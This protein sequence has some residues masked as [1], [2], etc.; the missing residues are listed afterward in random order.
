VIHDKYRQHVRVIGAPQNLTGP[1]EAEERYRL[2]VELSPDAV[3][4]HQDLKCVYVNRACVALLGATHPEELLG[5]SVLDIVGPDFGEVVRERIRLLVEEGKMPPLMEQT[6]LRPDGSAVEVEVSVGTCVFRG[7]PAIQV[8]ARDIAERKRTERSMAELQARY[9]QLVE[10]SPDA[11]HIQQDGK[12]VFVNSACLRLFGATAPEK[13]L[14]RPMLDFIHPD[15]RETVRERMRIQYEEKRAIPGIEQKA[16]RLDGSVVEVEVKSVPFTFEGR[17]AIQSVVRDITERTRGEDA[18]QQFRAAMDISPDLILLID[19]ASMRFVDVNDTTCR[20]LG[21]R[22]EELLALGP[23]DVAPVSREELARLYDRVIAGDTSVSTVEMHHRRKDGSLVPVE[24]FRRAVPSRDGHI[25]VI[26]ARD[27][28]E[29][30]RAER[31]IARVTN[32]YAA[33]SQTNAAIIRITDRRALFQEVCRIAVDCAQFVMA[34]VMIVDPETRRLNFVASHGVHQ[35]YIQNA[36]ISTDPA[37]PAGQGPAGTAIREGR[38]LV[39]QDIAGDPMTKP[40]RDTLLEAGFRSIATFPLRNRGAVIGGLI[41]YAGEEQVFDQQLLDL[42]SEMSSNISF[43]LDGLDVEAQRKSAEQLL[44]ASRQQL[45]LALD[46][47][48]QGMWDWDVPNAR[49]Y[50]DVK[51]ASILGYKPDELVITNEMWNKSIHPDDLPGVVKALSDHQHG[52]ANLYEAEYRAPGQSADWIWIQARGRVTERDGH[53]EPIRMTGTF[54][55]ITQRKKNEERL[56]YLAQYDTLTN[57]PNRSLFR[58]RLH[59]AMLR[60]K[61]HGHLMALMFLDIDRFKEINDTLGHL[62]GDRVLQAVAERLKHYVR[63]VDTIARLG[64]DEYTLILE[65]ITEVAQ[66]EAVAEKILSGLPEPLILEGREIFVSASIGIT[67][68]QRDAQDIEDLMKRADVAMYQAKHEGRNTYVFYSEGL[69]MPSS[70]RLDL[71]GSLRHAS[72]QEEFVLYYQPKIELRTGLIVGAEALIRWNSKSRGLVLPIQFIS[73]AEETGLIIEIGEWVLR[74]ACRQHAKWREQG[75]AEFTMAVNLS[76]RQLKHK[77]I[78]EVISS[79]LTDSGLQPSLLELEITEGMLMQK[80]MDDLLTRLISTGV[81]LSIDDFG[82]GYANLAYLKRFR[83]HSLK[84][85]KSFVDGIQTNMEDTAIVTAIIGMA[86]GLGIKLIAEGVESK[87]QAQFLERLRC[88]FAQGYYFGRPV[89]ADT[90]AENYIQNRRKR[91][92]KRVWRD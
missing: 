78:L 54:Q 60:A 79:A 44:G 85:D 24:L 67:I 52:L 68:Y 84:I 59:Q 53:G 55:D 30:Q 9:R 89:P 5:R 15:Q 25:I 11:I 8:I 45:Q 82:T 57:L 69:Q 35:E 28:T 13:L 70:E 73:L 34:A 3:L 41:L 43:A 17:P 18:L 76:P 90:F 31:R 58:D 63:E 92:A 7:K 64:G 38:Y 71:E 88:E 62:V 46:G 66:V 26:I 91:T 6:Y 81:H 49:I 27:I 19:R 29:R 61:R 65:E 4:I 1:K 39:C 10:L 47:S 2:L 32:L 83:V 23:H 48:E 80:G 20:V 50:C 16:L 12:L 51:S 40:W 74:A 36:Y 87:Q 14:G 56:T 75:F 72:K 37:E 77:N 21:Y 42:L 22:R 86:K 33:L